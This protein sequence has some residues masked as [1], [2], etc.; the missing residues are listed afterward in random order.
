MQVVL[1]VYMNA[2]IRLLYV[3]LQAYFFQY[4][5]QQCQG[6]SLISCSTSFKGEGMDNN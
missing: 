5:W 3:Y 1:P 6:T 2:I 4:Y